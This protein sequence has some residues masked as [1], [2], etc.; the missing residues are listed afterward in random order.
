MNMA[1][2]GGQGARGAHSGAD[3]DALQENVG[4]LADAAVERG[5]SFVDAARVQ[6]VDYAEQRKAD[7]A[8]SVG[9]LAKAL[10]ESGRSFDD[11]PNIRAVMDSAAD[12]LDQFAGT[13]RDRSFMD[14]YADAER[15]ARARPAAVAVAGAVAGFL[16]ARFVKASSESLRAAA[17]DIG[18]EVASAARRP[19]TRV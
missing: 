16:V 8:R 3:L 13:V 19:T 2:Q 4:G 11:R 14:L 9:D 17:D 7:A 15:V 18:R 10:R 12:G 1:Q 5:W 6:A